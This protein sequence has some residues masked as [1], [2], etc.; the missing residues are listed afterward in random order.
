MFTNLPNELKIQTLYLMDFDTIRS[1]CQTNSEWRALC[2]D[3]KIQGLIQ[4]LIERK[5]EEEKLEFWKIIDALSE[6]DIDEQVEYL[7][8]YS[9]SKLKR[10]QKWYES[11]FE[12]I[13]S[14][15][16]EAERTAPYQ[17]LIDP[18]DF[19]Y[20]YPYK[21]DEF[22]DFISHLISLGKD[23][24]NNIISDPKIT[25]DPSYWGV[26]PGFVLDALYEILKIDR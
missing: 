19:P 6:L 15:L 11:I 24:V 13:S 8:Q 22:N 21:D 4:T 5:R 20:V 3:P 17:L 18:V 25:F 14:S 10:F 23:E 2:K 1:I 12:Q 7:S 26:E 16:R 9:I